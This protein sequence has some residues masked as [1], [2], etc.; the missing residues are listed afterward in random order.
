[1]L[2]LPMQTSVTNNFHRKY[3]TLTTADAHLLRRQMAAR[4]RPMRTASVLQKI[5]APPITAALVSNPDTDV[6]NDC[7]CLT[8]PSANK[9]Y[10]TTQVIQN[11]LS[12]LKNLFRFTS[13][14]KKQ[15][16]K[17]D[18]S[19]DT[20]SSRVNK[21]PAKQEESCKNI[22]LFD[23]T[24]DLNASLSPSNVPSPP[25]ALKSISYLESNGASVHYSNYD[26]FTS[27][28]NNLNSSMSVSRYNRDQQQQQHNF[29]RQSSVYDS[30]KLRTGIDVVDNNKK[31]DDVSIVDILKPNR[32]PLSLDNNSAPWCLSS[33]PPTSNLTTVLEERND[34]LLRHK[35]NYFIQPPASFANPSNPIDNRIEQVPA[36]YANGSLKLPRKNLVQSDSSSS[37]SF[38]S[39]TTD[40][41]AL[42]CHRKAI[43][44]RFSYAQD[45]QV[46]W[47]SITVF[48]NN[49]NLPTNL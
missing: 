28:R 19:S 12:S 14:S 35:H 1:M 4:T 26:D 38:S 40:D 45:L 32:Q 21:T 31:F 23:K 17:N 49:T 15:S 16:S 3:N 41:S 13:S 47:F 33:L 34:I 39:I 7:R 22:N 27:R 6:K 10:S 18:S 11:K 20:N 24:F 44:Y 37:Q 48:A 46:S 25:S 29:H 2:D 9:A 5:R 42:D 30:P 8:P 43:P 36:T